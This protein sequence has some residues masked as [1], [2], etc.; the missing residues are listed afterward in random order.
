MLA[1]IQLLVMLAV[2]L[3]LRRLR[4][5]CQLLCLCVAIVPLPLSF[6]QMPVRVSFIIFFVYG[7]RPGT[8]PNS[9][10]LRHQVLRRA[11]VAI[12]F[13]YCQL[14]VSCMRIRPTLASN[15]HNRRRS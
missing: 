9:K 3:T 4:T 8:V 1:A 7:V 12:L 10:Q 5:R 15:L 14:F 6:C 2:C 11:T 13:V